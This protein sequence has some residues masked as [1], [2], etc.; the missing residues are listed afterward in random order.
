MLSRWSGLSVAC[1]TGLSSRCQEPPVEESPLAS[2]HWY[3]WAWL[4]VIASSTDVVSFALPVSLLPGAG[5]LG[6]ASTFRSRKTTRLKRV[7]L[8]LLCAVTAAT[9]S[10]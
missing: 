10:T 2:T 9:R 1:V 4:S 3:F 6:A 8:P 5:P 7:S